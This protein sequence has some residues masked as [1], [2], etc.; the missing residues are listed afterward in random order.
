MAGFMGLKNLASSSLYAQSSQIPAGYGE[1]VR[2]PAGLLDLPPGFSYVAISRTGERMNDGF[3]VPTLHDG[4]CAFDAGD[5]RVILIRNSEA[6]EGNTNAGPFAGNAELYR[7][8]DKR[9]IYDAGS[10]SRP[11][12]GGTTTIVYNTRS[13][14][15]ESQHLTLT[16]T[17]RNCAGG[18]TPWDTWITCEETNL[19]R[20]SNATLE[21]DHGYNFEVHRDARGLTEPVALKAMGRMSHE[22]VAVDPRSGIV[23]ETEDRGDSLLYR[24]IPE[25]KGDL[26]SG[27]LQALMIR[28]AYGF[29]T[30][31]YR[32]EDFSLNAVVDCTWVD[33]ENVESPNDDLRLQGY[34]KGAARFSRG[35]GAWASP[36]GAIFFVATDGGRARKGQVFRYVPSAY[37]GRKEEA[38]YPGRL[39][40]FFEPNDASIVDNPDNVVVAPWGDLI[41]CEDGPNE[42]FVIGVNPDG[43]PYKF[44]RNAVNTSE[45][46]GACFSP[47]GETLF[48]NIQSPGITFA[49]NG[50]WQKA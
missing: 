49:I 7:A 31:N 5:G 3:A 35:E 44:A 2:D 48:V 22:A 16:G 47:D 45:F 43:E 21:K 11:A 9:L 10:G 18:I 36:E 4:M 23:Y 6:G 13:R 30:R 8:L 1:L 34:S 32:A 28:D 12:L 25:R 26:T 24:F 50:P 15:V 17:I 41:L 40:L 39:E 14:Q 46:C 38:R 42:Q 33:I 29:D 27:R 20:G 37:E 19:K